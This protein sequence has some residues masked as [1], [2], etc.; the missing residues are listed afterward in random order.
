MKALIWTAV[1]NGV[2]AVPLMVMMMLLTHKKE[3]MGEFT[4]PAYLQWAGWLAT[5]VMVLASVGMIATIHF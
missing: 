1:L 5:A 3:V 4:L 2:I